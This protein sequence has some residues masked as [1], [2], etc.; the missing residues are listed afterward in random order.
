MIHNIT[1]SRMAVFL[2]LA[3]LLASGFASAGAGVGP[4]GSLAELEVASI[5]ASGKVDVSAILDGLSLLDAGPGADRQAAGVGIPVL[6]YAAAIRVEVDRQASLAGASADLSLIGQPAADYPLGLEAGQS[7]DLGI[8][9]DAA[10]TFER[11]HPE[12]QL[13]VLAMGGQPQPDL[14]AEFRSVDLLPSRETT[15]SSSLAVN[16]DQPRQRPTVGVA[17]SLLHQ[18]V[19]PEGLLR[20]E[21]SFVVAAWEWPASLSSPSG[22]LDLPSGQAWASSTGLGSATLHQDGERRQVFLFVE[23]GVMEVPLAGSALSLYAHNVQLRTV[24]ALDFAQAEGLLANGT[25]KRAHKAASLQLEGSLDTRTQ[26]P[27]DGRIPLR[28]SGALDS[29][30][31]DGEPL[32]WVAPVSPRQAWWA[33][34]TALLIAGAVVVA[35]AAAGASVAAQRRLEARRLQSLEALMAKRDYGGVVSHAD[36]LLASRAFGHDAIALKVEALVHLGQPQ[37]ALATLDQQGAWGGDAPLYHY[38]RAYVYAA[39]GAR[40]DVV[41]QLVLCLRQAP[42]MWREAQREPAFSNVLDD[43][44]LAAFIQSPSGAGVGYN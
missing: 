30:T 10:I 12:Y 9:R 15:F 25:G 27:R 2:A 24:G 34:T 21:G 7:E 23:D 35:P 42:G 43:P 37:R 28:V 3:C 1:S 41:S 17:N 39:T 5:R 33:G 44:R 14:V 16:T 40:Q 18:P 11:P 38:L 13:Y 20:I 31:S 29:A 19:A 22:N 6:R 4:D 8:Y 32:A 26:T 36:R